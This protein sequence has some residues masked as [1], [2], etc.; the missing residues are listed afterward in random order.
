MKATHQRGQRWLEHRARLRSTVL[1]Q[2]QER[3]AAHQDPAG[4]ARQARGLVGE[5]GATDEDRAQFAAIQRQMQQTVAEHRVAE[6]RK[7]AE[8]DRA[9]QEAK[10]R[11]AQARQHALEREEAREEEAA[12]IARIESLVPPVRG[13]LKLAA[14]K[15]E[16]R[17]WQELQYKT[18]ARDLKG[19]SC[20][21]RI[22]LLVLVEQR[23]PPDEPLWSVLLTGHDD[24]EALA[25]YRAVC[26]RLGRDAAEDDLELIA[27]L[28]AQR[29]ELHRL[30]R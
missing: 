18:G 24:Q 28:T 19:L 17:T 8:A 26:A 11:A 16:V 27:Q 2:Y 23:T 9:A 7:K 12:R 3:V 20:K 10:Q 1:D 5:E 14:G 25:M 13:G 6:A 4:L 21:D 15:G 30:H 29:A 22:D